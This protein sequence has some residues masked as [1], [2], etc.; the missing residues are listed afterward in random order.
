MSFSA[1]ISTTM[2]P[3]WRLTLLGTA[4]TRSLKAAQILKILAR[5]NCYPQRLAD[6]GCGAGGV[7]AAVS[8]GFRL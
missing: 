5:N 4:R 8:Q 7:L 6:V 2:G 3:T 1:T